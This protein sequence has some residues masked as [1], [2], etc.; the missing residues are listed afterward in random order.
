M[1]V[2]FAQVSFGSNE[3]QGELGDEFDR[4]TFK[5]QFGGGLR[6]GPAAL[7]MHVGFGPVKVHDETRHGRD[8][9]SVWLG[10]Q[11]RFFLSKRK[12]FQPYMRVGIQRLW[13]SGSGS[14]QRWCSESRTCDA[15]FFSEEPSY[16]GWASQFGVGLQYVATG[17]DGIYGGF[18][19]DAGYDAIDMEVVE[20]HPPGGVIQLT[21]GGTIGGGRTK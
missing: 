11:M 18:F 10:P 3:F 14:V 16:R 2:G 19:I 12:G 17:R 15:G 20:R 6:Y 1:L 21:V 4:T 8:P 9:F 13:I 5:P 7:S